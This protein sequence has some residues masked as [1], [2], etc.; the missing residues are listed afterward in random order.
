MTL[1]DLDAPLVLNFLDYLERERNNS[2]RTRNARLAAIRSF[3]RYASL[4][5]PSSLAVAQRVLSIPAKR[6]DRPLLGF[7]SREEMEALLNASDTNT[8]SGCR[9]AV[10][11]AVLYNTGARVSEITALHV[12]DVLLERELAIHLHGKGRKERVVPIW[13]NTATRL[14]DWI[15]QIGNDPAKPVFCNR[16]GNRLTRSGVESRLQVAVTKAANNCPSLKNR[17]ISPHSIRH[18]TAMHLLQ[19][20]V[21]LSVI[22]LWLGHE[23]IATTHLY[24]EADLAM[25][26]AALQ[27][28]QEPTQHR[29]R[30]RASNSILA[31]LQSL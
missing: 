20:G 15:N 24:V 1:A 10:L 9:D 17:K 8:W 2:P 19:S 16:R 5:V 11:L 26:E 12:A 18:S 22:A 27:R 3:M 28:L 14:R 25:K 6:F 30:Y 23:D 7:L 4:R 31:F 29:V 13:K 21:D